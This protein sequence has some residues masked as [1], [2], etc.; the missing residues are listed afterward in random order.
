M[1]DIFKF[2]HT[3]CLAVHARPEHSWASERG[4]HLTGVRILNGA[5]RRACAVRRG[6]RGAAWHARVQCGL[7]CTC[8][9][10]FERRVA[11]CPLAQVQ[12]K[13]VSNKI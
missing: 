13:A 6:V 2:L 1:C 5:A 8:A 12:L 9:V 10:R 4:A 7:T 3:R 11:A